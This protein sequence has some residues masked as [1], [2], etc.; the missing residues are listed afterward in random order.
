VKSRPIS[1]EPLERRLLLDS[2]LSQ[3]TDDFFDVRQNAASQ[4]LD[5][6]ANDVFDNGYAGERQITAVSYGSEGG[7]IELTDDRDAIYYAPPADFSGT[8]TFVYFVDNELSG[9]VSITVSS[10]LAS[11]SYEILPDEKSRTLDVLAN[12]PFGP[13]YG[14][15]REISSVSETSLGAEVAVA[16]DGKSVI[17][18]PNG[19]AYGKD[20]FVYIVDEI[21]PAQVTIEIPNPLEH[22]RYREIVQNSD[23]NVLDLLANDRFWPGYEGPRRITFVSEPSNGGSVA[24]EDDGKSIAYSPASE[25]NGWDH[26]TYVVDD[27]FE[28]SVE[29]QVHR[30]VR[31][32]WF[33]IDTN[34]TNHPLMV[35]DNDIFHY[36]E[37]GIKFTR[38]VIDRVT[39]VGQPDQGGTVVIM[40]DGQ[41]ILYSAPPDFEGTDTFEYVADGKHSA[42]V[43]VEITSPV[44]DDYIS[45]EVF[46]DTVDNVLDVLSNDFRGN[47]YVGARVITSVGATSEGGIAS[48]AEDGHSILFTPSPGFRGTDSFTYS[49][50]DDLDAEV[51]VQVGAIAKDDDF[52]YCPNPS[53]TEF[54]LHHSFREC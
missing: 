32:D 50:D 53:V 22:D 47:G 15:L 40:A 27:L 36:W 30:P 44:R 12:D 14:G 46:E 33:E 16:E 21:Y 49:V 48:V 1:L 39:S 8:E 2:G 20:T 38:D 23:Q 24:I 28:A 26:F 37:D 31:D 5:V 29:L 17:Y 11:D 18:T 4:R 7:R 3:L 9:T 42:T 45:G 52:H 54:E 34:T 43:T 41:G 25:F 13:D 6:L 51:R 19:D 35:T 10:P